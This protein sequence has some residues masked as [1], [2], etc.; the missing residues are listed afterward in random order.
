MG[1]VRQLGDT[2]MIGTELI[3]VAND[4]HLWG[5]HYN[6]KMSDIFEVQEEIAREI[7]DKLRV[8]LT[9]KEQKQLA[10]RHTDNPKLTSST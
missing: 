5:E 4:A 10:K 3:D 8:K 9:G 6:R 1:R 2:L 7:S